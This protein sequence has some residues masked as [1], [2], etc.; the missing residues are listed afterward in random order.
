MFSPSRTIDSVQAQPVPTVESVPGERLNKQGIIICDPSPAT[1]AQCN[2]SR[3]TT[4]TNSDAYK[5]L[6]LKAFLCA[7]H[8][9]H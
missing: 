4:H 3:K 2:P 8:V 5:V 6:Q 7:G 1:M 9:G